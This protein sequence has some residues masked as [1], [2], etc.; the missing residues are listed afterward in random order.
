MPPL[1]QVS[2]FCKCISP[3]CIGGFFFLQKLTKYYVVVPPPVQTPGKSSVLNGLS[4]V[5]IKV[6][7]DGSASTFEDNFLLIISGMGPM[8]WTINS[9]IYPIWARS[10]G[11]AAATFTN[12]VFNLAV[13]MSFLSLTETLTR[14][15]KKRRHTVTIPYLGPVRSLCFAFEIKLTFSFTTSVFVVHF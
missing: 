8:P 13:S 12:W 1:H 4:S 14:Y 2:F 10:T 15:G 5:E 7:L 6:T 11:N 9:E 3:S